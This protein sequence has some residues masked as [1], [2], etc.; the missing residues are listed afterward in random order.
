MTAVPM[1]A[2]TAA[3]AVARA[4]ARP[5]VA[6]TPVVTTAVPMVALTAGPMVAR[7]KAR[8]TVVQTPVATTAVPTAELTPPDPPARRTVIR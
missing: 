8:P 4:R 7:V 5:T 1:V 3:L 6:R 2:L